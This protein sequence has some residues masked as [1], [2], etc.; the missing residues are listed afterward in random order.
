MSE[1]VIEEV[2]DL[3]DLDRLIISDLAAK[4]KKPPKNKDYIP[5]DVFLPL[6]ERYYETG[7]L[8]NELALCIP[9]IAEGLSFNWRFISYT[10]SWKEEMVGDAIEKMFKALIG[11]KFRIDSGFNPFSYFNQ[12]AWHCFCNRIKKEKKQH[13]GLLEY[14]SQVYDEIMSDPSTNGNVYVR[15]IMDSDENEAFYEE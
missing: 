4:G 5:P 1:E 11:K 13:D 12:I 6:L 9:K 15:P 14:K 8:T 2:D 10:R 3:N 7:I